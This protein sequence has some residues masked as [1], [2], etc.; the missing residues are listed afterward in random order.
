MNSSDQN[1]KRF[2]VSACLAGVE[3]RY[4]CKAQERLDIVNLV[5]Q[6]KALPVCPEQLGGLSTPR[7]PAEIQSNGSVLTN[8]N[9]DVTNEYQNGAQQAYKLAQSFGATEALLKSKSPMCGVGEIYD[10]SFKGIITEGDGILTS[11]LK[12]KGVTCTP[13]D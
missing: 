10:G 4:D 13:I 7:D 2:L 6:G 9:R 12:K 3:C 5:S 1:Q 11:L 8:K